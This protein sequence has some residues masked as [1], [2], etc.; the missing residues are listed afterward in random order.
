MDWSGN[1]VSGFEQRIK[2]SFFDGLSQTIQV[3]ESSKAVTTSSHSHHNLRS[4]IMATQGGSALFQ[5]S[6]VV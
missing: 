4:D 5:F 2:Y 6:R 3:L 1:I